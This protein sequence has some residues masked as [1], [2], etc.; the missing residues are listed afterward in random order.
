MPSSV[1]RRR[2]IAIAISLGL[3]ALPALAQQPVEAQQYP[4]RLPAQALA[5]SLRALG[6][7]AHVNIVFEPQMVQSLRAPPL[8][9][10]YTPA[11]AL[12]R[13]LAGSGLVMRRTAGGSWAVELEAA[14]TAAAT[15]ETSRSE[16]VAGTVASPPSPSPSPSSRDGVYTFDPLLVLGKAEG[17][18]VTRMPTELKDIPQSVSVIGKERW[19]EQNAFDLA[20]VLNRATGV[21]LTQ[22]ESTGHNFYARGFG[23]QTLHV[24]GG[25]PM[26]LSASH[27]SIQDLSQREGVPAPAPL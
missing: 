8:E 6:K 4:L 3:T 20:A 21:T 1:R 25:A 11:E 10:Q 18:S 5:D 19:Q 27:Y 17:F 2:C 15:T 23:I 9:G 22:R 16:P 14:D 7:T 24:D 13:L 12:E 26:S